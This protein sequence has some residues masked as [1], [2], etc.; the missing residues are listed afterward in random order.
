MEDANLATMPFQEHR[1]ESGGLPIN[2]IEAGL[3]N[4]VVTLDS[5]AWRFENLQAML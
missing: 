4:T 2:Y 1:T 5:I 3:G